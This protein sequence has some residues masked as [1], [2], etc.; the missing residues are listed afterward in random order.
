MLRFF[1]QVVSR[2]SGQEHVMSRFPGTGF[3]PVELDHSPGTNSTDAGVCVQQAP[4]ALEGSG[5][6]AVGSGQETIGPHPVSR[7]L[8]HLV[9]SNIGPT[10]TCPG[11]SHPIALSVHLA[12]LASGYV[13]CRDCGH[14]GT[15][16]Q[17]SVVSGQRSAASHESGGTPT[18]RRERSVGRSLV[19]ADG[20]R[21][22]YL[23]E[24]DRTRAADWGAA[25][26][27]MLW[28]EQPRMGRMA[29][30]PAATR[31]FEQ[32]ETTSGEPSSPV[33]DASSPI[34]A[35]MVPTSTRRG[36]VVVIGFDERP[37]SPDIIVGVALGLRRMGCHVI[38]LGQTTRPCFH[39]AVHHLEAAGGV[40]VTGTGCDPAWTGFHFAGRGSQPWLQPE[41][42]AELER[43]AKSNVIR[44]TRSAGAQR[45]FHAA[46][47][48]QAGLWKLFHA[49]RPLQVVCGSATRQLPR[50]LDAL[51]TRL[52][53]RLTHEILPVRRRD[54]GDPHDVDVRRVAAATVAGQ[55]H[56]GLIVDDDGE[57]CA[58]VTERGQLVSAAELAR[59]LVLFELHEHRSA[60]IVVDE[61][62]FPDIAGWL[63][64]LGPACQVEQAPASQL[65]STVIQLNASLGISAQHRLWFGGAYPACNAILTLARVL[66]ALS[67]SDAPMSDVLQ[68]SA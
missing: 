9:L 3:Q 27:S 7:S 47:P 28:D 25:F 42:L 21:G 36:P 26:A 24:L 43:R 49:L 39:F 55:H 60:R 29:D 11:D 2:T 22:I 30:S 35:L 5:Q 8:S 4:R 19:T 23:N 59:L 18:A 13:E 64:S 56:L 45:P 40:F 51:F 67:L 20:V 33:T 48:Y 46:V 57:R 41:L 12:R 58:F 14:N 66:Q 31:T 17:W 6:W 10:F 54:L 16:G 32:A 52:P 63:T 1:Q 38:D 62:L 15:A 34:P 50:V 65:P 53:C 37:S 68:R 61:A 44:P